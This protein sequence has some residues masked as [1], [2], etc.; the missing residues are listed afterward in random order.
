MRRSGDERLSAAAQRVHVVQG[1]FL[2]VDFSDADVVYTSSICFEDVRTPH[3][4]HTESC[5]L[6]SLHA[7]ATFKS[8]CAM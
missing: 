6:S 8:C 1:S 5:A 7:L 3:L 2:E 4:P